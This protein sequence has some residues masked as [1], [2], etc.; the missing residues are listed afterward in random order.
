M[1]S[2]DDLNK[3]LDQAAEKAA[4]WAPSKAGDQVA[5]YVADR[6]TFRHPE[7][8]DSE[9][10]TLTLDEGASSVGG[11]PFAEATATVL[12]AGAVLNTFVEKN[13]PRAGDWVAIRFLGFTT[14]KTGSN[15]YKDYA[16]LFERPSLDDRLTAAAAEQGSEFA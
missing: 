14:N 9:I 15:K 10:L 3:R 1:P 11:K 13:D 4:Q 7:Y 2:A 6:T 8:G 12:M 5:G 16:T